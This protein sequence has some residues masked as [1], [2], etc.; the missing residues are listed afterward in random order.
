MSAETKKLDLNKPFQFRDPAYGT[1]HGLVWNYR[2]NP[3]APS[4]S[5]LWFDVTNSSSVRTLIGRGANGEWI[6]GAPESPCDIINVHERAE[7]FVRFEVNG[8]KGKLKLIFG[9][10]R[11]IDSEVEPL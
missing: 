1:V 5:M 9:G 6:V 8:F 2:G 11:L 7:R 4:G 10:D 3:N